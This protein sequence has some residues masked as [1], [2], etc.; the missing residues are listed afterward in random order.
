MDG[1]K[2]RPYWLQWKLKKAREM[3]DPERALKMF[4][5]A[6]VFRAAMHFVNVNSQA[7]SLNLF[8]AG[9]TH[10]AF[11]TEL[12]LKILFIIENRLPKGRKHDLKELFDALSDDTKKTIRFYWMARQHTVSSRR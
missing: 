5:T 7:G 9:T 6:E 11:A 4:Q 3:H 2:A 10:A 1:R 12:Y 8:V